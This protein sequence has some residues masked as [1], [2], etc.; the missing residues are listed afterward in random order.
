MIIAAILILILIISGDMESAKRYRNAKR[1]RGRIIGQREDYTIAAYGGGPAGANRR[2]YRQYEVEFDAEGRKHR[3][4][5]QTKEKGL[6]IGD[7]IEVRYQKDE[8][9]N[10]VVVATRVFYD[11][12][13]E[14]MVGG[15]LGVIL[16]AVILYLK[17]TGAM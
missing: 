6:S 7:F 8:K 10:E 13:K 1:S 9:S 2:R 4:V 5:I 17:M 16:S 11:R 12:L 3:G 15:T 14:L